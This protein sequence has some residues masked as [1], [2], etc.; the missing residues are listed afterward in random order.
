MVNSIQGVSSA[1]GVGSMQ[2]PQ[3]LTADQKTT[4]QSILSQYDPKN[5]T[6]ADAKSIFKS[7]QEAGIRPNPEV[8]KMMTTA[9]FDPTQMRSLSEVAGHHGHHHKTEQ[10]DASSSASGASASTS[11]VDSSNLQMLQSILSQFADPTNTSSDQQT[12]L[13]S[14]LSNAGLMQSGS[15]VNVSA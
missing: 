5:I 10:T 9:G 14:Q 11:S 6:T 12:D 8:S 13:L 1:Y 4:V 3:P 15:A 7:L 2:A